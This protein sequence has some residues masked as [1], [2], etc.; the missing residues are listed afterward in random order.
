LHH[1]A[2]PLELR[3]G[4]AHGAVRELQ[5][6]HWKGR[7]VLEELTDFLDWHVGKTLDAMDA[8][9]IGKTLDSD[10]QEHVPLRHTLGPVLELL[11]IRSGN[12][13]R[14]KDLFDHQEA[15]FQLKAHSQP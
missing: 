10:A 12:G 11:G 8:Q 7:E 1:D 9:P 4:R 5:L 6:N 3:P 15:P 14:G 13:S 2:K